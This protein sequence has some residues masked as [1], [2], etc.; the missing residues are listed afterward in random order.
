MPA[1]GRGAGKKESLWSHLVVHHLFY[2]PA[3]QLF[4][5]TACFPFQRKDKFGISNWT[6][7]MVFVIIMVSCI[8]LQTLSLNC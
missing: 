5:A 8:G 7:Q 6:K 3:L 2:L 4:L 1:G